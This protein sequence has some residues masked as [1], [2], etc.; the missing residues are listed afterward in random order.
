MPDFLTG[1]SIG[2]KQSLGEFG[3]VIV[4][5]YLSEIVSTTMDGKIAGETNILET[6]TIGSQT[7]VERNSETLVVLPI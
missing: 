5:G 2:D 7:F 3:K 4:D 1:M 6:S